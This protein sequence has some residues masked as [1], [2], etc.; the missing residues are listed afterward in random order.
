MRAMWAGAMGVIVVAVALAAWAV[1]STSAHYSEIQA[2]LSEVETHLA[3]VE[4]RLD[5]GLVL[6]P[7]L[8]ASAA[9]AARSLPAD[10]GGVVP[11]IPPDVAMARTAAEQLHLVAWTEAYCEAILAL[12]RRDSLRRTAE[13][14]PKTGT[15]GRSH[16]QEAMG[17]NAAGE[18]IIAR[19]AIG[20]AQEAK[21][22]FEA[23]SK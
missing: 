16:W 4:K 18:E 3:S 10:S 12:D 11:P 2:G 20:R 19:M 7:A 21:A 15:G 1:M 5:S 6:A 23:A 22:A 17:L 9:P 14:L 13:A 8:P